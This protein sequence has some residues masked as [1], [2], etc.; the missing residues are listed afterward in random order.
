MRDRGAGRVDVWWGPA[1]SRTASLLSPLMAEGAR[2]PFGASFRRSPVS[3]MR[4]QPSRPNHLPKATPPN[5]ITLGVRIS[6]Y[7]FGGGAGCEG[8][9][10]SIQSTGPAQITWQHDRNSL[11]LPS[12]SLEEPVPAPRTGLSST[13]QT[14]HEL[15]VGARHCGKHF[16]T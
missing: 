11:C 10:Y 9:R 13:Q 8:H 16:G 7:K 14:F 2:E 6:T 12:P 5:P 1:S 4:A 15:S 3:F